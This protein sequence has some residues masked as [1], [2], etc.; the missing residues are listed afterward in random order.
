M[1]EDTVIL[2][3]KECKSEIFTDEFSHHEA[4]SEV[5]KTTAALENI[6]I[7][8][9]M[10]IDIINDVS[11]LLKC[12]HNISRMEDISRLGQ[13]TYPECYTPIISV[14]IFDNYA[15]SNKVSNNKLMERIKLLVPGERLRKNILTDSTVISYMTNDLD[16][17][18]RLILILSTGSSP[19]LTFTSE[20]DYWQLL[21]AIQRIAANDQ[22]ELDFN[23]VTDFNCLID[24]YIIM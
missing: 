15:R 14:L 13:L 19:E 20:S 23:V 18:F 7:E 24:S 8:T 12:K 16:L 22:G 3:R 17:K 2:Q 1:M 10:Y 5:V 4:I 6:H 9:S 11:S 21:F